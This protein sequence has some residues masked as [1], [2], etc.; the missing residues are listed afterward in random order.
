VTTRR[1]FLEGAALGLAGVA[2]DGALA[3]TASP[4][5][6]GRK[7][8]ADGRVLPFLGNT[9]ICHLPQQGEHSEAF[10]ALLDIYRDFPAR[11]WMRKVTP[12][13][14]SSYH[15]TVFG[16]ANDKAR[17][18]PLWPA[19]LPL[20]M[21]MEACNAIL[22]ERLSALRM[23]GD[24]PPYRMKVNPAEPPLE[25]T[26][27]TIRLLPA[28]EDTERRLRHLRDR[29]SQ[30]TGIR[31]PD[32]ARYRFHITLGYQFAALSDAELAAYRADLALWKAVLAE[33][34]PV[35]TL[36]APEFCLLKDMFAFKRQ[37]YLR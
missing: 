32:H 11:G 6:V 2:A 36:G 25:E 16:G 12:L 19:G 1:H 35:I 31:E 30:V 24:A 15:M 34:V 14:P 37:F 33:K 4:P 10:D 20:D 17:R 8:A 28:D 7:F 21:P 9:I 13:P 27:L 18:Y 23:E 26:P 22:A 29:I 3:Q 5:D